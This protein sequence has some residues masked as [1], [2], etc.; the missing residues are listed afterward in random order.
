MSRSARRIGPRSGA[1]EAAGE[2]EHRALAGAVGADDAGD[3]AGLGRE[4]DV[5]HRLHAAE[6]DREVLDRKRASRALP[7]A[8]IAVT[9][10]EGSAK[11]SF[12]GRARSAR[13]GRR[14]RPAPAAARPAA[15]SRRTAADTA[16]ATTAAP[17]AAPRR[18]RRP[19]GPSTRSA[20]P[21]MTTSRNR[22][23]WKNGKRLRADEVAHGGEHAA[24]EA[25]RPPP[26][27]R[28]PTVRISVGSRP[29]DWLATSAS[30][31][32]RMA[33]PHGLAS[34]RA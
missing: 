3:A 10:R 9:S 19:A 22:I 25:R 2:V 24:G 7:A 30:R 17:A 26:R 20:P 31:T 18:A 12:V 1:I 33:L 16:R 21:I 27:A 28:R 5:G 8:S 15:A 11:R 6:A 29:I 13:P 4:R 34:S 23:D 14:S 32:A